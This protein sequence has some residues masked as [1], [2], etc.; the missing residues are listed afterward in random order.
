MIFET[1]GGGL[2]LTGWAYKV[3]TDFRNRKRPTGLPME[4]LKNTLGSVDLEKDLE[5]REQ[6]A[7]A[8][9]HTRWA[10]PKFETMIPS[11]G[12]RS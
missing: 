3:W 2:M 11:R 10:L 6:R 4:D 1:I 5:E 9:F 7:V 12:P 8:A